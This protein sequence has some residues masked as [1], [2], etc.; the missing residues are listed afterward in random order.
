[1]GSV[2]AEAGIHQLVESSERV[3]A[4]S[5]SRDYTTLKLARTES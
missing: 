4:V 3:L 2:Q 5:K 1:M